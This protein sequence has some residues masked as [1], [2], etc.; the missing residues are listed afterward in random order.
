MS[1]VPTCGGM[2]WALHLCGHPLN[3]HEPSLIPRKTSG[4]TSQRGI[5]P[6]PGSV[7][8]STAKV[9]KNKASLRN[10]HSPEELRG[11]DDYIRDPG[12]GPGTV[13]G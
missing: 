3:T 11:Q 9:I 4:E 1:H 2:G 6:P 5:L 12:W 7:L 8:P 10:H 13:N